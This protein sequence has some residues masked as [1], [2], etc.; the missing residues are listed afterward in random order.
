MTYACAR[1][2]SLEDFVHLMSW[3]VAGELVS[4]KNITVG[5]NKFFS[6]SFERCLSID[7]LV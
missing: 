5:S 4:P 7:R 6:V 2:S 1:F 3:N